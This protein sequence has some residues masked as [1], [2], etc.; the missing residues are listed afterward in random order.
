MG[1]SCS[2]CSGDCTTG[3]LGCLG[4]GGGCD[5]WCGGNCSGCSGSC[6]GNCSGCSGSCSGSCSGCTSCTGTCSGSCNNACTSCRGT[7]QGGCQGTCK[8][9]CNTAC[10]AEGQAEAIANLG[11]NIALGK[12]IKAT[13]Y[14]SMKAAIDKEYRRRGKAVP[15]SFDVYPVE[16]K[17]VALSAAQKVLVDVYQF[18]PKPENDWRSTM[19][20]WDMASAGKWKPVLAFVKS[21]MS[22][23]V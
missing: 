2:N 1:A 11:G 3:C 14:T 5:S 17:A 7:C 23:I 16:G 12:I 20:A 15:P 9:K 13:D 21:K 22:E 18:D 6:G 19:K 4:C 10:T 8:N